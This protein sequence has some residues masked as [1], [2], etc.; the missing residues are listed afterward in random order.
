LRVSTLG[1]D[2]STVRG[3]GCPRAEVAAM[4]RVADGWATAGA[5]APLGGQRRR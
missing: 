3:A 1:A 5:M 4:A 2:E